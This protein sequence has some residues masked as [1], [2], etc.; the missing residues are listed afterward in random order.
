MHVLDTS[1]LYL[2]AVDIDG[3]LKDLAKEN[4][5]ALI[6]TM[7]SMGKVNLKLRGK[8]V[9]WIN[10]INM[11]F[12]KTGLLPTNS[13][14]QKT[15]LFLY[16]VLLFKKYETFKN[17]YFKAYNKENIFFESAETIIGKLED[18]GL[19]VYLVTKNRQNRRI[20]RLTDKTI[21]S[22]IERIIVGKKNKSKYVVYKSFIS[23]RGIS[24][25]EVLI[26]GDNFWDDV[27]PA[28]LL[29]VTVVWCNMYNSKLKALVINIFKLIFKNIKDESELL[30]MK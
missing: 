5:S 1:N 22:K 12:V 24:K 16:S 11:Y 25:K 7:K 6:R 3:T 10:K 15:L 4:T 2:A 26:I 23:S 28:I 20:L 27:L 17:R 21:A 19:K 30:D 8:F 13:F 29:G 14:M 18:K 9:L